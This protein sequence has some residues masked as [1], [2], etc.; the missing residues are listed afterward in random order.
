MKNSLFAI[1]RSKGN[2]ELKIKNYEWVFR[3]E[4]SGSDGVIGIYLLTYSI[5]RQNDTN[6]RNAMACVGVVFVVLVP[7]YFVEICGRK[8]NYEWEYPS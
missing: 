6:D 8:N 5:K 1:R 7:F 3:S 2:Y 4:K